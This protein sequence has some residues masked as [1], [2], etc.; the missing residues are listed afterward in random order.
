[1]IWCRGKP[2]PAAPRYPER[3]PKSGLVT[4][5]TARE[6]DYIGH[7]GTVNLETDNAPHPESE[8]DRQRRLSRE[9]RMVAEAD[10]DIAADRLVD[11]A[12][13]DA[14]IDSIGTGHELPVPYAGS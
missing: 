2:A 9:A 4:L 1:M 5:A 8:T 12:D 13:V 11:E 10:A 3:R 14:W 6:Q 7:M